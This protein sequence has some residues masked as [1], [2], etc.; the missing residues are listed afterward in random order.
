M[1]RS[2]FGKRFPARNSA[3]S[4]TLAA[5]IRRLRKARGWTQDDLAAEAKMEQ[6]AISLMENRRANPTLLM[7][8]T[9][10][11]ALDVGFVDLFTAPARSRRVKDG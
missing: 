11:K 8:E 10:A 1:A 9:V 6:A 5:N 3:A 4:K 7:L 2:G